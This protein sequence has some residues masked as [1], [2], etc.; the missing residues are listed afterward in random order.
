MAKLLVTE[1]IELLSP[2]RDGTGRDGTERD[3][4]CWVVVWSSV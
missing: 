1:G 4:A 3:G 2:G